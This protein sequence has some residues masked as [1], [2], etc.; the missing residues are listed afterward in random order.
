MKVSRSILFVL[1]IGSM[2]GSAMGLAISAL[3]DRQDGGDGAPLIALLAFLFGAV[4]IVGYA[5]LRVMRD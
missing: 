3:R 2:V 1:L 5:I 4:A